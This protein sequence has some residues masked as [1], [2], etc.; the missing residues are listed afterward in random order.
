MDDCNAADGWSAAYL[1][2]KTNPVDLH[3][4]NFFWLIC[5]VHAQEN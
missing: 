4:I 1:G 5:G 2:D 3:D